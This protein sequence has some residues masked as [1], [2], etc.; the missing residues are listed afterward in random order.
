MALEIGQMILSCV[1]AVLQT[2][3]LLSIGYLAVKKKLVNSQVIKVF[4]SFLVN[5]L[6]P[7]YCC[8]QIGQSTTIDNISK[9]WI[10]V[11]SVLLNNVIGVVTGKLIWKIFKLDLKIKE[12]F[13]NTC[14]FPNL[15]T[16]PLVVGKALCLGGGPFEGNINCPNVL[17]YVSISF[18]V[19]NIV[20]WGYGNEV[21][22]SDKKFCNLVN[23]MLKYIW[24]RFLR[25]KKMENIW[26]DVM[27]DTYFFKDDIKI[28]IRKDL[29]EFKERIKDPDYLL[30]ELQNK[31]SV[32]VELK[33]DNY[34]DIKEQNI[35]KRS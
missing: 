29:D 17:G 15:A 30:K 4:S 6:I 18:L 21:L 1:L 10:I 31:E 20:F 3:V 35:D 11:I 2:F 19:F 33:E 32:N 22:N 28:Q 27:I 25:E 5:F 9:Y 23:D 12:S 13:I 24:P 34:F 16:I 14:M 26:I 7:V 8:I